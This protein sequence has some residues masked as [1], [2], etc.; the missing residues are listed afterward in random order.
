MIGSGGQHT[1]SH[2]NTLHNTATR[3]QHTLSDILWLIEL[4]AT[5]FLENIQHR[6]GTEGEEGRE[7]GGGGG[8][9]TDEG[10]GS[11]NEALRFLT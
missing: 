2:C 7:E 6:G 9:D 11:L 1:A 8:Y 5:R 10:L 3:C 4:E